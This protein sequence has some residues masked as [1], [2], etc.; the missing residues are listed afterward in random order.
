MP[1]YTVM[2]LNFGP[3]LQRLA[4]NNAVLSPKRDDLEVNGGNKSLGTP[5]SLDG[6]QGPCTKLI[7]NVER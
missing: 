1:T 3:T 7:F 2:A 5:N 4:Y 6:V